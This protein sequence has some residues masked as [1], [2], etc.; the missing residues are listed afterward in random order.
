MY[1]CVI[2]G[3][4]FIGS[5]L[6]EALIASGRDVLVLGRKPQPATPIHAQ[7]TYVQCDY[8]NRDLLR[9]QIQHVNEIID[10]AYATVPQTSFLDPI[11]DLQ[12]NL[13]SSVGLL[14]EALQ[15]GQLKTI[16]YVSSGGTV[17][18]QVNQLPITEETPTSPVSPYGIT[19]LTVERYM[20]MYH[21]LHNLPAVVVR[22]SNAYG[23]G[24]KPFTGQGFIAT[25]MGATLQRKP[26]TIFGESGT[27]RDYVHVK[28]VASG[29]LAALN[30]GQKGNVYNIGSGLGRN[31]REILA[32]ISQISRQD[33]FDVTI[34]V[35]NSRAFD[36]T[37]NVLNFGK[38]LACSGWLPKV[39]FH[40]GIA[41][42]WQHIKSSQS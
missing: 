39:D 7:A 6:I 14:E 10:L 31:N 20:L 18:G 16:L 23:K 21:K 15:V 8:S 2:G 12:S 17:Y 42:M 19:K 11:F 35:Q 24:Q 27:V 38:L 32:Q 22:P 33:G 3:G 5:Y 28:D 40:E 9:A 34:D 37:A 1:T 29:I 13:P 25:A 26:V 41:E 30:H 36:V 4:G